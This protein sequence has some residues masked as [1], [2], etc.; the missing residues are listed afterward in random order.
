[1]SGAEPQA[2]SLSIRRLGGDDWE[3][4]RRL[5]LAALAESPH[6]F[7]SSIERESAFGDELWRSR[8]E[9]ST[10]LVAELGG[11]PVGLVCALPLGFPEDQAADEVELVSMWVAPDGR[12]SGVG[13]RLV[14]EAVAR[15]AAAGAAAVRL[16]VAEGNDAATAF[17]RSVGFRPTS[18]RQPLPHVPS[19]CEL[20]MRRPL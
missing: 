10:Y 6:A 13:S 16:W 3:L 8:C 15:A 20:E 9:T 7:A 5:R 2:A 19:R 11:V 12:R 4:L 17:Y 18:R 14:E 1:M